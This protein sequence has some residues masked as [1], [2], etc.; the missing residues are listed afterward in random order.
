MLLGEYP[1]LVFTEKV[2]NF[3]GVLL[4]AIKLRITSTKL[5]QLSV[6]IHH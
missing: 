5:E 4:L 6:D 1:V 2:D 3:E